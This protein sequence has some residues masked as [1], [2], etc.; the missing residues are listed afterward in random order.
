MIQKATSLSN[1]QTWGTGECITGPLSSRTSCML[2]EDDVSLWTMS[3]K[4]QIPWTAMT[5]GPTHG[6]QRENCHTNSLTMGALH[7]SV[8][9]VLTFSEWH[10]VLPKMFVVF[11][12]LA[13]HRVQGILLESQQLLFLKVLVGL[14]TPQILC[15]KDRDLHAH[16][17]FTWPIL[18]VVLLSVS[19]AFRPYSESQGEAGKMTG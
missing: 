12:L 18:H 6:H 1:V 4:T 10:L 13:L 7:S 8:Y 19:P 3:S 17:I 14:V 9:P 5:Q 11:F 16:A 2:Q 15:Q